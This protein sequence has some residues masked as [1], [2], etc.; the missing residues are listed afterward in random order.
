MSYPENMRD[1]RMLGRIDDKTQQKVPHV[2]KPRRAGDPT[3][4]VADSAAAM[5]NLGWKPQYADIN[6]IVRSAF[7][8]H[9]S[10]LVS[11]KAG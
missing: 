10:Q 4:L 8:W 5:Q 7:N 3:R 11:V 6:V 1:R 9:K 2:F